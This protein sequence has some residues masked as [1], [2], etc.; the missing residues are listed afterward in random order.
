MESRSWS[1]IYT[2]FLS[3]LALMVAACAKVKPVEAKSNGSIKSMTIALDWFAEPDYAGIFYAQEKG[4]FEKAGIKVEIIEGRGSLLSAEAV[5]AGKYP[6]AF[7][8]GGA[9]VL[10][11]NNTTNLVSLAVLYPKVPTVAFGI[12]SEE[13]R[14]I[15]DLRGK[16]IGIYPGSINNS[17]WSAFLLAH[18]LKRDFATIVPISGADLPFIKEKKVDAVLNYATMSPTALE[19]DPSIPKLRDQR[20]FE[21]PLADF[22][23]K[24]YGL[25]LISSREAMAKDG[26]L[27]RKVAAIICDAYRDGCARPE[28]VV[29]IFCKRFPNKDPN[30]VRRSWAKACKLVNSQAVPGEQ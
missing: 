1:R 28:E 4:L 2:T 18:G 20:T 22:G 23:V 16:R 21:F 25:N 29:K 11:F 6:M 7:C 9:T 15:L 27:L 24:A 17:E 14:S 12:A 13:I 3:V 8:S 5:A 26:E 30:Y 19:I 10:S